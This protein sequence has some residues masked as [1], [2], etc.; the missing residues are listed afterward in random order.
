MLELTADTEL[1]ALIYP[2]TQQIYD[3]LEENIFERGCQEPLDVWNNII[4]DGH[5]RYAI[6]KDY[7]VHFQ[8]NQL[9]LNC[10]EDAISIICSKQ[11]KRTDLPT[12]MRKYLIGKYFEA[13]K[14]IYIDSKDIVDENP[15]R[16]GFQYRIA[17]IVGKEVNLVAGTVYKYGY[18]TR[19]MDI[20]VT[21]NKGIFDK[22]I[23]GK[24]RVSHDNVIELSRLPKEDLHTLNNS[25]SQS[26][27]ARIGYS[28]MRHELH[29]KKI[30]TSPI[31]KKA[32]PLPPIK[33]IP[34]YD[35]DAEIASLALTIPSWISSIERTKNTADF[36]K[37]TKPARTK[38][39]GSLS[40]LRRAI[41]DIQ[42]LLLEENYNG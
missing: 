19:A 14:R 18:Y 26:K 24:L 40:S 37:T 17:G 21:K 7:G 33:E 8:I 3:K 22:I 36:S 15:K 39:L 1:K 30:N 38:L 28:E 34:E 16:H 42:Q 27:Q 5:K 32:E 25:I 29:W 9:H 23:T 12:E 4:I 2:C 20:I 31:K 13:Q 6:C 11:L 10:R 35:P 41:A